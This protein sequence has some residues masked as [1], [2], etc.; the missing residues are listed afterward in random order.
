MKIA[1]SSAPGAQTTV[2]PQRR[3][4]GALQ[5]KGFA[6]RSSLEAESSAAD[7]REAAERTPRKRAPR[8]EG[9]CVQMEQTPRGWR[10]TRTDAREVRTAKGA[11]SCH[12]SPHIEFYV[13]EALAL[14]AVRVPDQA[15]ALD[16]KLG[17]RES[18]VEPSAHLRRQSMPLSND[19]LRWELGSRTSSSF[20]SNATLPMNTV[21]FTSWLP[22]PS[23]GRVA[24][25]TRSFLSRRSCPGEENS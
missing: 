1:Q 7:F 21:R 3:P 9:V 20:V 15:N 23:P 6:T 4:E 17:S 12:G 22:L 18:P 13:A 8:K 14:H 25:S 11:R 10:K 19:R 16:R 24:R 2:P 5:P